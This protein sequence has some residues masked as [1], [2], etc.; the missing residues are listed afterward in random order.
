M[1]I[2]I[3]PQGFKG[4]LSSYEVAEAIRL[5]IHSVYPDAELCLAPIADGGDGFLEVFLKVRKGNPQTSIVTG[6]SGQPISAPWML[7]EDNTAVIEI[8]KICGI[9]L[10]KENEKNPMTASTFGVGELI[11]AALNAGCRKFIL[12]LGG[13]AT[14]DG[15]AGMAQALGVRLVDK[16][17][18]ELPQGGVYLS[19][20]QSIDMSHLDPRIKES[21][22]IAA[23]DVTNPLLGKKGASYIYGPQKGATPQM[24]EQLEC[25]LSHFSAVIERD[26]GMAAANI[27]R[28]GAAGGLGFGCLVFLKA[29]LQS[30]IDV[31]LEFLDF[32]TKLQGADLVITG[33]GC[34][35][36]QTSFDKGPFG[37]AQRALKHNIPVL[38]LV[39][40]LGK[41]FSSLLHK[42][43]DAII[44][45]SFYESS[46][47]STD[48][49]EQLRLAAEQAIRCIRI[50]QNFK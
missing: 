13:S 21:V 29:N 11:L 26:S 50:G 34:I 42:G 35:D 7:L 9:S 1:K 47:S 41:G 33:E 45:L 4:T 46:Y 38:A 44:P 32:E 24:V 19:Q 39:G 20:L 2:L 14:N 6:G 17:G 40:K 22:F 8:A 31:V 48:A 12:G 37:V 25:A 5:G 10:L 28:S 36:N 3:A 43:F 27:L 15:G 18:N 49:S 30:G 16:D 23:C